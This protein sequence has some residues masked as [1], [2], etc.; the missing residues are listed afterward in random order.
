LDG[1]CSRQRSGLPS[2]LAEPTR[3]ESKDVHIGIGPVLPLA[4]LLD[5]PGS[6]AVPCAV[7]VTLIAFINNRWNLLPAVEDVGRDSYGTVA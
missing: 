6:I 3:V 2:T 1:W 4:W 7:V 5:V